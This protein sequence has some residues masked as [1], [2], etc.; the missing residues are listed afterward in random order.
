MNRAHLRRPARAVRRD[1]RRARRAARARRPRQQADPAA[2]ARRAD[3]VRAGRGAA[4][5]APGA[6]PRRADHRARRLDAGDDA[7]ASSRTTTSASARRVLLT[8]HYMD[9]VVAL[10]PRVI[11]IDQRPA[12]L[13]R[14]PARAGAQIRP[15]KRV[16]IRFSRPVDAA[17]LARCGTVVSADAAQAVLSV[18]ARRPARVV[19]DA[20][21]T[22]PII[23]LAIEDPPLEEVMRELFHAG[24][25]ETPSAPRRERSA[26]SPRRS[27]RPATRSRH[28]AVRRARLPGAAAGR[29]RRGGRLPG[30][31]SGL[32]PDDQHAAGHAGA[33]ARRRRRRR[34][35]G[36]SASASSPP[37]TS[38][39]WRCAS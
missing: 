27:A 10:C 3:E 39:R 12:D 31:V 23:D 30:R 32:D 24:G 26:T 1:G 37:I 18:P 17:D 15:D 25:R 22:L 29:P 9:D 7:R 6:V 38:A 11:V 34:R 33:V 14:R 35:S 2:V 13:R 21:A 28:L 36:G 4:A 8:S 5:P 19:R 16:T 20:L